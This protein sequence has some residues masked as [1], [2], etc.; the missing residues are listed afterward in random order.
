MKK[1]L[2]LFVLGAVV[3]LFAQ[4]ASAQTILTTTT[5]SA[6]VADS[7]SRLIVVASATGINAPTS[8]TTSQLT[9]PGSQLYIDRELI[10]VIGI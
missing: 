4:F 1:A 3:A 5:L 7:V 6:K 2:N 8:P 9:N 10:D